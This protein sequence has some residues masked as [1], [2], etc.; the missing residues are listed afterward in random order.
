MQP[1]SSPNNMLGAYYDGSR[2][3]LV[4]GGS[5]YASENGKRDWDFGLGSDGYTS[6]WIRNSPLVKQLHGILVEVDIDQSDLDRKIIWQGNCQ[7][8]HYN[9]RCHYSF[10]YLFH[11]PK[12]EDTTLKTHLPVYVKDTP[13]ISFTSSLSVEKGPLQRN[14]L[15]WWRFQI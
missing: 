10:G 14:H 6:G 5:F 4:D 15:C 8:S 2:Y 7:G 13:D 9:P 11:M 3:V 12:Y 1:I